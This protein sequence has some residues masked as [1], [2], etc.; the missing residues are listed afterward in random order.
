MLEYLFDN[1][2]N[3][4]EKG[5]L[6]ILLNLPKDFEIT[7]RNLQAISI[8]SRYMTK[9]TLQNLKK[10]GYLKVEQINS[11]GE[12]FQFKYE[13]FISPQTSSAK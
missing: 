12:N 2:L 3:L 4:N 9:R 10:K 8:N 13:P 1:S 6:T 5:L 7:I 11:A